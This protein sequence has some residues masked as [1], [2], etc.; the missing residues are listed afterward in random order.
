MIRNEKANSRTNNQRYKK[1]KTTKRRSIEE[2]NPEL[3]QSI[4]NRL[5]SEMYLELLECEEW[6]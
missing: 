6:T 4:A 1:F 2:K 5:I 3:T